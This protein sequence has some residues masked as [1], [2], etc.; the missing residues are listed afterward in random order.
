M[1]DIHPKRGMKK[2]SIQFYIII[3]PFFTTD[4]L[5]FKS[6]FHFFFIIIFTLKISFYFYLILMLFF[7]FIYFLLVILQV[8]SWLCK[9]GEDILTKHARHAATTLATARLHE[10]DFEKFY[11]ASMVSF[12]FIYL[13]KER[14][15]GF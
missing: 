7:F 12:Y 8:L 13:I 9:K 5:R 1:N 3:I 15:G 2:N 10:R 4:A 6:F 14:P 11:F